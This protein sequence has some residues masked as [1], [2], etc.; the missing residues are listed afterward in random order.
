MELIRI[1]GSNSAEIVAEF[2]TTL[3]F[4][5]E[6]FSPGIFKKKSYPLLGQGVIDPVN[7][8]LIIAMQ[9]VFITVEAG[10]F[11]FPDNFFHT[12]I[13]YQGCEI[14]IGFKSSIFLVILLLG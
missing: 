11:L 12:N 2:F 5:P 1:I 4:R 7:L 6:A 3:D 10:A 8:A 13:L 14:I 9:A